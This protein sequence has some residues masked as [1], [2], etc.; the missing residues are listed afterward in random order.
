MRKTALTLLLSGVM[1][2]ATAAVI[3][4]SGA[5]EPQTSTADQ[6]VWYAMISS[7][8]SDT[9]RQ[10]RWLYYDGSKLATEQ[11]ASGVTGLADVTPYAWRLQDNGD[12]TVRIVHYDGMEITVPAGAN[13]GVGQNYVLTMSASGATWT[14]QLSS[15]TGQSDCAANQYVLDW[16]GWSGSTPAYLNAMGNNNDATSYMLTIYEAGAHQAS[17]WFFVPLTIDEGGS[18]G[19]GE[20]GGTVEPDLPLQGDGEYIVADPFET[21][22]RLGRMTPKSPIYT[23]PA[24][25]TG[26]A[27]LTSAITSGDAID[28]PLSYNAGSAPSKSFVV[29]SRQTSLVTRDAAFDLVMTTNSDPSSLSVTAW[30]DWNRDGSYEAAEQAATVSGNTI[31]QTL[32]VPADASLGKTRVRVRVES[33]TPSG[34]D[35]QMSSGRTYDFVIYVL[36]GEERNDCY[37]S[38]SSSDTRYGTAYIETAPNEDGRYDKGTEVTVIAVPNR[39]SGEEVTFEGWQLGG[40]TLTTDTAYTFTVTESVHL[41]A[42]FTV[43]GPVAPEVST[44][45]N[46]IW[47]QIMNAHTD[48]N[49]KDRYLAYDTQL[50]ATY[51]SVLR[52]ERPADTTAK[53]LWR[54][55]DAGNDMVYIVNRGSGL[56]IEGSNVLESSPLD[57]G[58]TGTAFLIASSGNENG[59]W[60]IMYQGISDRLLNAQDGTWKIVLYNAGIGTGSGW[61]FTRVNVQEPEPEP[62]PD[63]EPEPPTGLDSTAETAPTAVLDNSQVTL[64]HLPA[65]CSVRVYNLSG[66]LMRAFEAQDETANF[67]LNSTE[68]FALIVIRPDGQGE[69]TV[70][71]CM[72]QD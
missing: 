1:A 5:V 65:P 49:R 45:D 66:Q 62:D 43:P 24:G 3:P 64:N 35:A 17:G 61:Y 16:T 29:V 2:A 33:T 18:G 32:T 37:V 39:T 59:S 15:A 60:S 10:N 27:F 21:M 53:F 71:K 68:R 57:C 8:L 48:A 67:K 54:L 4:P 36:E 28:Y 50:D 20:G 42:V 23:Q 52:A 34:A 58:T 31:T 22:I 51:T 14:Y 26:S 25:S 38:V 6:P 41:T 63:P 70:I 69:T 30:T 13:P 44:E 7:H 40:E 19:G 56:R 72:E 11:Y 12:G 55:E 9:P 46:P 47:Y